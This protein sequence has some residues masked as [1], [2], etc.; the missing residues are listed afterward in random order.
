MTARP[1]G[2]CSLALMAASSTISPRGSS[3]SPATPP[4]PGESASLLARAAVRSAVRGGVHVTQHRYPPRSPSAGPA[5]HLLFVH[6]ILNPA[7]VHGRSDPLLADPLAPPDRTHRARGAVGPGSS[8]PP[9]GHLGRRTR[10][11]RLHQVADTTIRRAGP[12]ALSH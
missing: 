3:I 5:C 8:R 7:Y 10:H 12:N 11:C 2:V 4:S 1:P 9:L 6:Q